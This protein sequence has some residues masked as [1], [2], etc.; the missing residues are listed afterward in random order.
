MGRAAREADAARINLAS[1]AAVGLERA[2]GAVGRSALLGR[3]GIVVLNWNG[4]RDTIACL[5]SLEHL[6]YA[7]F[8]VVVVDNG[9]SDDSL[10]LIRGRSWDLELEVIETGENL[11]YAGGNNVGIR[12]AIELG[13]EFVLVL[14]NDTVVAPNLLDRLVAA[15]EASPADGVF[16]P[17]IL[18]TDRP[19][20]LWFAGGRWNPDEFVFE[21]VGQDRPLVAFGSVGAA[22]DY[23]CGAALFAR[24]SVVQ[25]IGLLDTRFFLVC[26]EAD[27][28][29]RAR[30]AGFGCRMVP[31]A[32]VWHKV[33]ASF[34]TEASP[35]RRYYSTRN[36]L[37]WAEKN[38]PFK[39]WAAIVT[40][41]VRRLLPA[42]SLGSEGNAG[43]LKRVAW[44]LAQYRRDATRIWRDP[45]HR[46]LRLGV[47]D[48]VLR[49]FGMCP[50]KVWELQQEWKNREHAETA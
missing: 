31:E 37:L 24:T 47:R 34:G 8:A 10:A 26:E 21:Y 2:V 40:R 42:F 15:A 43:A 46:A 19:D 20:T 30:R 44:G 6:D 14:N 36:E 11:G 17:Y 27:W 49:R 18:Y 29:Y 25:R 48:Y 38:L 1:G 22:S 16:G 12:R 3:V 35:L 9:S 28:C 23:V 5:E 7:S 41:S 45:H 32:R 33:G 13:C 39:G 4:A 50:R